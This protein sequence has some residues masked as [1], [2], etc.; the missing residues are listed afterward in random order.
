MTGF[1]SPAMAQAKDDAQAT[2]GQ[3]IAD[4]IVTAQRR[5]ESLQKTPISV[6]ALTSDAIEARGITN[7][8][9]LQAEIPNLQLTPHPNSATTARIFIRGVGNLDDQITQDPSVAIYVDG[10]YVGRSQG[11]ASDIAEIERIEVLRGPQ[12]SLYGRNATGGAI[13]FVSRPPQLGKFE[14]KQV[15]SVGNYDYF[16]TRTRVNVPVGD[17]LAVELG[18][19][20]AQKDGFV[21]NLGTGVAR[22]GD[23]RRDGYRAA[24][25]WMPNSDIDI[26]YS[27]D[28]TDIGDTPAFIAATP[29]YPAMADRPSRSSTAVSGLMRNDVRTQGH[30]LTASFHLTDNLEL[31]S[32]TG[33][34]RLNNF[35]NQN[36]LAGVL[37]PF[38]LFKNQFHDRQKQFS[39]EFQLVG[40]AFDGQLE[41]VLGAYYFDESARTN[42]ATTTAA[43]VRTDRAVTADNKAYAVYGQG[44]WTPGGF[45]ERL[46][47]TAGVRWSRDKRQATL[48][49]RITQ[50]NGTV[51]VLPAGKGN[52]S[53]SNVSPTFIVAYDIAQ[54]A[55]AYAK[56]SRGYKS[57]GFNVRASTTQ[58]FNEGFGPEKLTA[59]E[60][61]LK[62]DL[63]DRH[64]RLNMAVFHANY[65]DIQLN[66]QTDP[67]NPTRTDVLNAGKARIYGAEIDLVAK[68]MD[69]LTLSASYGYTNAKYQRIESVT[70]Q[71]IADNF[72]FTNIPR[73]SVTT[74]V[75]YEFAQT[76]FGNFTAAVNYNYQARAYASSNDKRL[77]LPD[78]G[79]LDARLTLSD[80]PVG[81]A[82][83]R[84][85]LWGHNLTDKEYLLFQGSVGLPTSAGAI[86][87]E[88]RSYGLDLTASF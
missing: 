82:N 65:R 53:F 47:L 51:N 71:N 4:I 9:D 79:L 25:R 28:R 10:I 55:S 70:G 5:E 12:G 83:L 33:Y 20:H 3:G 27:Y 31:R 54:T 62:S 32:L 14:A 37:G 17:T 38:A 6:A 75:E 30:N 21:D 74:G 72:V 46:H 66:M 2:S 36:Y 13:N 56:V 49:D 19:V 52:N 73:N 45:D 88:P 78:Y 77:I 59:Y 24:V 87:G 29:L 64:L 23:Q 15:V 81:K 18:Y 60:I 58:R 35:S 76:S 61:G 34:R 1:A 40:S 8:N 48:Q 43:N 86:Y 57:G 80:I 11:L 69:G 63:F 26:R 68:P 7:V 39:Q 84:L 22:F 16:R 44:T 41:Y 85:S 67:T 50:A 42:A